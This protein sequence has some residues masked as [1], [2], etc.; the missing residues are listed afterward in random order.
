MPN[1]LRKVIQYL[2]V[3]AVIIMVL[4]ACSLKTGGFDISKRMS[5]IPEGVLY[6]DPK[7]SMGNISPMVYGVNHGPWA[8][9]NDQ[10]MPLAQDAGLTMIRFPGGNWG[11]ENDLQPYHID[12]F[13]MLAEQL[14]SQISLNVR[15]FNGTPEKAAELVRYANIEKGYGIK[16]W[17]IGNEPTLFATARGVPEYGVEQFNTE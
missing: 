12:Q 7:T 2:L 3:L 10:L 11:D 1:K 5:D 17:G 16:Y 6:V 4:P 14:Q 15:L 13:A 9:V 8:F